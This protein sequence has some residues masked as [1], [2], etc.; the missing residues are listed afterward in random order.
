[1]RIRL[2][3]ATHPKQRQFC[4]LIVLIHRQLEVGRGRLVCKGRLIGQVPL[5]TRRNTK[6]L[7]NLYLCSQLWHRCSFAKREAVQNCANIRKYRDCITEVRARSQ[8]GTSQACTTSL[9]AL[10]TA[11][12]TKLRTLMNRAC[13]ILP[14]ARNSS[15]KMNCSWLLV[16]RQ[17]S[18]G[19]SV[20]NLG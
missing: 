14:V 2:N 11:G 17:G 15:R 8:Q 19:F 1:M 10:P 7:R 20:V 4:C 3:G 18:S 13:Q 12:A 6:Q 16:G 5:P 9:L